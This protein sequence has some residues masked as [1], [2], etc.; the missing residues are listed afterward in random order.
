MR[1]TRRAL[2]ALLIAASTASLAAYPEKPTAWSTHDKS[3]A[4]ARSFA[5]SVISGTAARALETGQFFFDVS[6]SSMKRA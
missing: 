6:A 4:Q 3:P 2:A 1:F 5:S